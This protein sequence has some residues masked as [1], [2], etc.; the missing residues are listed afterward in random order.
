MPQALVRILAAAEVG[1]RDTSHPLRGRQPGGLT[2]RSALQRNCRGQR[3]RAPCRARGEEAARE[4]RGA[5]RRARA[6]AT[7]GRVPPDATRPKRELPPRAMGKE[8]E[9]GLLTGG[10]EAPAA[11]EVDSPPFF[12]S[13]PRAR[14]DVG[15]SL[16]FGAVFALTLVLGG[17]AASKANPAY[18]VLTSSSA[19]AVRP[20]TNLR[21]RSPKAAG[22]H[23]HALRSIA[24]CRESEV[25]RRAVRV[26]AVSPCCLSA[27]SHA[28]G[29]TG[30]PRRHTAPA[31]RTP[32][33]RGGAT[34]PRPTR[35]PRSA[36]ATWRPTR[37]WCVP[38]EWV[39]R[40][41]ARASC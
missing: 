7:P 21:T 20:S 28:L 13:G 25:S 2:P 10:A 18:E 38:A 1:D 4:R 33:R 14:R 12:V 15:W 16:A 9:A 17:V 36:C 40:Q 19:L 31:T 5:R 30:R 39:S 23:G 35:A 29:F 3:G 37:W 41:P 24:P 22:A 11:G 27:L 8:D 34:C 26:V 32:P 6:P